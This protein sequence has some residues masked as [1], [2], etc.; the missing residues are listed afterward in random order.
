MCPVYVLYV[1]LA[2]TLRTGPAT[3]ALSPSGLIIAFAGATAR[4]SLVATRSLKADDATELGSALALAVRRKRDPADLL[5]CFAAVPAAMRACPSLQY[6]TGSRVAHTGTVAYAKAV[7][8][9]AWAATAS[10]LASRG[11]L[12]RTNLGLD[13]LRTQ[14]ALYRCAIPLQTPDHS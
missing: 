10:G 12:E 7:I 1:R 5:A 6:Y 11:P 13:L 3:S 9:A 14:Y 2:R 4:P 8:R